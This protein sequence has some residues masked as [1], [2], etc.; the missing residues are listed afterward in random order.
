MEGGWALA[1][2]SGRS[3]ASVVH[4]DRWAACVWLLLSLACTIQQQLQQLLMGSL[5]CRGER[6][7]RRARLAPWADRTLLLLTGSARPLQAVLK[8]CV[9]PSFN[10]RACKGTQVSFVWAFDRLATAAKQ[11][12]RIQASRRAADG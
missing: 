11:G 1:A 2:A 4:G 12:A 6:R 9:S 8:H 3:L 10:V 7:R 5:S